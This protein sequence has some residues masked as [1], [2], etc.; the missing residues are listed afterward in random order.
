M[1]AP[2]K[3]SDAI[4]YGLGALPLGQSSDQGLENYCRVARCME[5]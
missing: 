4:N 1:D 3:L 2:T 5:K